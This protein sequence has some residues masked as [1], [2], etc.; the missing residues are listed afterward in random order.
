MSSMGSVYVGTSLFNAARARIIQ[1]KFRE[2]GF[3]ISYDWTTHGQ[4]FTP[5]ELARFGELEEEG[6]RTCD[7]F[8]MIQPGRS[9]THCELGM[10]RVLGKHIVILEDGK[11]VEQKTF[12]YRPDG[13]PRPIHKFRNEDAAIAFAINLLRG[14]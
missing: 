7:L 1:R 5:A 4:V 13:H 2:A 3:D 10:A 14:Q 9:G 12:Y 8:F 6:V 11:A